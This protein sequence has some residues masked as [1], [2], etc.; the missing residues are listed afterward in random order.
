MIA[1]WDGFAVRMATLTVGQL[2]DAL[3][4]FDPALPVSVEGCDC[5]GNAA[6]VTAC[7]EAYDRPVAL[8]FR[9]DGRIVSKFGD[10][11]D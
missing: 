2:R 10:S 11:L 8:V 4:G 3:A 6:G 1:E 9:T 7:E 5:V